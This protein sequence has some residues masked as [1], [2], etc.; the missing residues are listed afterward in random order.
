MTGTTSPRV[1][2]AQ[3]MPGPKRIPL[4]ALR[5]LANQPPLFFAEMRDR[6]GPFVRLPL[7]QR[8]IYLV[9][10]P[11]AIQEVLVTANRFYGNDILRSAATGR[12]ETPL[13]MLLGQGLL[14]SDGDLH[15][16]QRRLIQPLFHRQRIAGYAEDFAALSER[17]VRDWPDG[18]EVDMLREMVTL[19]L[20]I[21]ARTVFD[22]ALG[23]R[24]AET[25]RTAMP[26]NDGPLRYA[27][28]PMG[29]L[30][31]RLPSP[32]NIRFWR[33][34]AAL[35]S[36]VFE[37]IARRRDEGADGADLLSLLLQARDADTGEPMDDRQ[38]RD[39]A[40]T[41]LMAGHD[42]T[43]NAL[44]WALHL[45]VGEPAALARL[46]REVD[47]VLDG[48]RATLEDLPRLKWTTAVFQEALRIFPPVWTVGRRPLQERV[49][50]GY[51][52]PPDAMVMMS[53][54]VVHRDPGLWADPERFAPQRWLEPTGEDDQLTGTALGQD[55]PKF[56][57]FPFGGGPRQCIG[58]VFAQMEAV[59]ALATICQSWHFAPLGGQRVQP[60]ARIIVRP[61][62]G[63]RMRVL[64]RRAGS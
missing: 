56:A 44:A 22:V 37:L 20:S 29:G 23:S 15:R 31:A 13:T 26:R 11:H 60:Q 12:R 7:P 45:L 2:A 63:L 10:D 16:R 54:W 6:H 57:Y 43:A 34:R 30:L 58:N 36:V 46:H 21:V 9:S 59:I 38:V 4:S 27:L 28:M 61:R 50:S 53:P 62:P 47:E 8:P 24:E 39:E 41:L 18:G 64:R 48:R 3:P 25:I 51:R 5:T 55:R 35:D 52:L 1:D 42:T 32:S 19:T 33:G 40:L 17:H 14:T 49:L